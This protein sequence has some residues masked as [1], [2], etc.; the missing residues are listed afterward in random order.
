[1]IFRCESRFLPINAGVKTKKR[2]SSARNLRLH[3]GVHSCFS[4]WNETLYS[5]WGHKQYFGEAQTSK[6]TSVAV[7]GLL[8]S[9]GTQSLLGGEAHFSLSGGRGTS[10][11]LGSGV[12]STRKL[13]SSKSFV[14]DKK[15]T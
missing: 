5:R 15:T 6:C 14:T 1:M 9:L 11:D 2:S 3:F 13:Y 8:L 4:S 7:A 12:K 10:S